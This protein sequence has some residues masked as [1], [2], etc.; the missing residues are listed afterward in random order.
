MPEFTSNILTHW[1]GCDKTDKEAFV[2]IEN[3]V[4]TKKLLLRITQ[5]VTNKQFIQTIQTS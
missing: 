5:I 3:I 2:I 4:N 1:T